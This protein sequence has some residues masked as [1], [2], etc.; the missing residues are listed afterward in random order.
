MVGFPPTYCRVVATAVNGDHAYVLLD[1][2]SPGR[3]YLYGS[4]CVRAGTE[5]A[6]SS[7]GNGGGWSLTDERTSLG[8]CCVWDDVD[9]AADLVRIEF[10]GR[11]A[12]YP[13]TNGI[14]FVIWWNQPSTIEP[15]VIAIRVRGEWV[16]HPWLWL[17]RPDLSARSNETKRSDR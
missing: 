10:D 16:E 13:V 5:W 2:G 11:I 7:S 4:H 12:D 3:P 6:E 8:L 14:Y 1:T 9:P 15:A 17:L